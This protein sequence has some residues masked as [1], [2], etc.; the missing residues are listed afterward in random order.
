MSY[1]F[2]VTTS[3]G[4]DELLREEVTSLC[5]EAQLRSKPGQV[6][7]TGQLRDAYMIC[8]WSRLANRVLLK[9]HGGQADNAEQLYELASAIDW[10]QHFSLDQRFV[11]DFKGTNRQIKNSQFGALKVK[12]AIVDQ[13]MQQHDARPDVDRQNPHVR[14][15]VRLH[16]QFA[17]IYLDLSGA[18]LH[19]RGYREEAGEAPLKENVAAAM[20]IRSGW[21][22][23]MQSPLLDPMCGS[24]TLLIEAA[25]MAAN[26]APGLFREAWGFS[27]WAGHNASLWHA[28]CEH[29]KD[30]QIQPQVSLHGSDND[31]HV[32]KIARRN[33]Q[34]AGVSPLISFARCDALKVEAP[35]QVGFL[36][37]NPPY[38]ERL[39]E[40]T[41]LIPLFKQWGE[42]LK[43]RFADWQLALLTS[44]R[45]LLKQMKL[46]SNKQY[47][48]YNG[49][50]ECQLVLYSMD[51]ENCKVV[52]RDNVNDSAFANRLKKNI[53]HLNKWLKQQDTDCFRMYDAD[54]P[55][56]NLAVDRYA[57]WLVV[58]EYAAP[59]NIPEETAR[60]RLYDA[61][62]VLSDVTGVLPDNI[63]LKTRAQQKGRAQYQRMAKHNERIIVHENGA[64]FYVNP[65]DYLDTGLFLD[66]RD[67]RQIVRNMANGK[68]VLNLFAYTGSVSVHAALG[69]ARS[70]TTVDMSS[71]YLNWAQDNFALNR[72][73]GAYQFIREDC[74]KWLANHKGQYDL[75][76]IDPPSF[77]NSKR[78]H[79]TWDVQRDHVEL[80]KLASACLKSTGTIIFSNNLRSFKLD[81]AGLSQLGLQSENISSKT[82]PEDFKRHPHIHQCWI[83]NRD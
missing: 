12:D 29:A 79:G 1:T 24:G 63:A 39:G 28:L 62:A 68:D 64:R 58:Q 16:R 54:L 43:Q 75:I 7:V 6:V 50:L 76:F 40:V 49:K 48:L 80:L 71:T 59:K 3:L 65:R 41:S 35:E 30:S 2:L 51:S 61:L 4:L 38:G 70:V 26:I 60:K 67:T 77:S 19:Q 45:E 33:A 44:N 46:R 8:L 34:L 25:L 66:H 14:I 5:P 81:E 82:L 74:I 13:F 73:K 11:V 53:K 15:Q 27:Y 37:C 31:Q 21:S 57:D 78:M 47:Q 52:A 83:L 9:L 69:G 56:Y 18:S 72:L 23:S 17:D 20:L 42:Q 32:L 22:A 55:E 36:V 10:Q